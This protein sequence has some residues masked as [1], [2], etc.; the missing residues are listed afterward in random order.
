MSEIKIDMDVDK[1][2]TGV[3]EATYK[4]KWCGWIN[5]NKDSKRLEEQAWVSNEFYGKVHP[6]YMMDGL[7]LPHVK[8]D[9]VIND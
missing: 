3:E 6:M 1:L 9:K 7:V 8:F 2:R 5:R 4:Y